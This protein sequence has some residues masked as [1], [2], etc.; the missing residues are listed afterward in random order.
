MQAPYTLPVPF[1]LY[2]YGATGALLASFV[3]VAYFMKTNAARGDPWEF[4]VTQS[5]VFRILAA[6]AAIRAVRALSVCALLL[7]VATGLFGSQNPTENFNVTFFWVV[8]A[9]GLTYLV[10]LVGDVYRVINPWRVLCE[11]V[12]RFGRTAFSGCVAYP[13]WL[14]YYPSLIL[15]I[16]FIWIE[17]FGRTQPLGLANVLLAYT[18]LNLLA[19][20]LIGKDNWFRYG[21]LFSVYF[22]LIGKQGVL[23]FRC[24]ARADESWVFARPPFLGLLTQ[25]AD[26]FSLLLFVLFMLSSTAFDGI[27]ET[28]PWVTTFWNGVYPVLARH[29]A[30]GSAQQYLVLVKFFYYWQWLMLIV[31]PFIYL[32]IYMSFMWIVKLIT[33]SNV[34]VYELA[35]QFTFCLVPIAFVYNATHYFTLLI[36][37]GPA[38]VAL[39]SDPFGFGW[40]LFG[41]KNWYRQQ[42]MLDAGTVWHVQVGLMLFGHVVSVY[43]SHVE[44]SERFRT[45]GQAVVSQLPLLA[46]MVMLTTI[47]LWILSLPIAAG[48]IAVPSS[49]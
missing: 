48:Q 32:A 33:Q 28:I 5:A 37:Q 44:A 29:F 16:A 2:A 25:R 24:D 8:F 36:S 7:T 42:Y 22:R 6:P 12:E 49:P 35:L 20:W 39:I 47:G 4:D 40:N 46:L 13:S 34:S 31:S 10:G 3:V 19:A 38:F 43:L 23:D 18:I 9:L 45:R 30:V 17:L 15:Y 14:A 27:H 21:E 26:H 41:T 11:L 1:W